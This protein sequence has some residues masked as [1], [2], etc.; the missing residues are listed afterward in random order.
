MP[1]DP[2]IPL[3]KISPRS[4]LVPN[5]A[6]QLTVHTNSTSSVIHSRKLQAMLQQWL[7]ILPPEE[8]LS[9]NFLKCRQRQ[10][11]P[12]VLVTIL[13]LFSSASFFSFPARKSFT[14]PP[15]WIP[16]THGPPVLLKYITMIRKFQITIKCL[17]TDLKKFRSHQKASS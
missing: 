6:N 9:L 11:I 5:F 13:L 7:S 2:N 17:G 1:Y 3:S 4:L 16:C 14:D 8:Q 10:R 15:P 12:T